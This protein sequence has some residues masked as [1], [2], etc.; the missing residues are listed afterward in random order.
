MAEKVLNLIPGDIDRSIGHINP[1]LEGANLEELIAECIDS[2]SPVEREVRD[3]EGRWYAMRIRPYRT[4]DNKIDG[5]VVALFDIDAPKRFEASVRSAKELAETLLQSSSAPMALLD[6]ALHVRSANR[7]FMELLRLTPERMA[8]R[9]LSEIVGL[10]DGFEALA[11]VRDGSEPTPVRL[12][13]HLP[14]S[15]PGKPLG[16]EARSFPAYDGKS[17]SLVLLRARSSSDRTA[18]DQ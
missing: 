11:T 4:A 13:V 18:A 5:A 2:I 7:P 10:G 8:G 9:P 14:G 6:S 1:N 15:N 16:F 3:R 12:D 17:D